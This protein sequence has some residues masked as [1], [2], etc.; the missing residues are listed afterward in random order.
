M[1]DLDDPLRLAQ[2]TS[3]ITKLDADRVLDECVRAAAA[4][5]D[6]PCPPSPSS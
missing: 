3:A 6:A 5:A 1:S 4:K 2:F